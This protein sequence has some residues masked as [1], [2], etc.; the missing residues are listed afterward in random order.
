MLAVKHSVGKGGRTKHGILDTTGRAETA[1]TVE[2]NKLGRMTLFTF[3]PGISM[4]RIIA[5]E[6]SV[7][8]IYF[9]TPG[10]EGIK[11]LFIVVK[12]NRL[13]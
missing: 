3:I 13:K 2:G 6:Q 10:V 9:S 5:S 1:L 4:I 7:N 12:E 11:N 8:V